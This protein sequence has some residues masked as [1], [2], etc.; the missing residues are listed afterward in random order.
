MSK[1][2]LAAIQRR[3]EN[4]KKLKGYTVVGAITLK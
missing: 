4:L 2:Q 1:V 3:Y